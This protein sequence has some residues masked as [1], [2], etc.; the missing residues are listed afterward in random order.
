[1]PFILSSQQSPERLY[2]VGLLMVCILLPPFFLKTFWAR[3]RAVAHL[4][5]LLRRTSY[6][7]GSVACSMLSHHWKSFLCVVKTKD[8]SFNL[9]S[10][11]YFF[12]F[13]LSMVGGANLWQSMDKLFFVWW[14]LAEPATLLLF[15]NQNIRYN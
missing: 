4:L 6:K 7:D 1:M 14:W 11:L 13:F 3:L 9:L 10:W 15:F 5:S 2:K 12:S 8:Y